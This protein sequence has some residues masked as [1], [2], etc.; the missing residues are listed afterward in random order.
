MIGNSARTSTVARTIKC[1]SKALLADEDFLVPPST[2]LAGL[3]AKW[4]PAEF[5]ILSY[6]IPGNKDPS[7]QVL[8]TIDSALSLS[9]VPIIT[10][11]SP[12]ADILCSPHSPKL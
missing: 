6:H 3:L 9:H 12:D 1:L 11:A 2:R 8:P 4:R 7:I 10:M 5:R